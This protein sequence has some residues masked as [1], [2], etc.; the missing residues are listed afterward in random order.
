MVAPE[1]GFAPSDYSDGKQRWQ[2]RSRYDQHARTQIRHEAV[3]MGVYIALPVIGALAVAVVSTGEAAPSATEFGWRSIL[4]TL[5][6]GMLGGAL[7]A[8]KWLY[9]SVGKGIWHED[10]RLWRV[11][12]PLLSAGLSI[13]LLSLVQSGILV[14]FDDKKLGNVWNCFGL[15]FLIGY[16]SDSATAK[17]AEVAKT[18]F[19]S[20]GISQP[21]A[22]T[23]QP[24][25]PALEPATP[26]AG[27]TDAR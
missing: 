24:A 12:T 7:Y 6:G 15:S 19:G 13:G 23:P 4:V 2:W 21:A 10:R 22:T 1:T 26:A 14:I 25:A 17:L 8:T 18:L 20:G 27:S 9:H 11:F 16:F 5:C 3:L